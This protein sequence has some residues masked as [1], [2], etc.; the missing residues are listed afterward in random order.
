MA[1]DFA[2]IVGVDSLFIEQQWQNVAA[3]VMVARFS[4]GVFQQGLNHRVGIKQIVA[5]GD[6]CGLRLAGNRFRPARF[7]FETDDTQSGST[8]ITPNGVASSILTG[9]LRMTSVGI[10]FW[11][12]SIICLMFIR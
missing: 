2:E 9:N 7:F 5:H 8:A 4:P 1:R 12:S 10:F 3:K 11:C 6:E